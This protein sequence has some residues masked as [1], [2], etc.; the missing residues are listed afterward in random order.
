MKDPAARAGEAVVLTADEFAGLLGALKSDGYQ[1]IGPTVRD[2]AIVYGEIDGVG[3]MPAGLT[4]VQEA[5]TYRIRRR[6]D[7]ALFGYAVGPD[8]WK[9][10]LH[11]PTLRLWSARRDENRQLVVNEER[12][13]PAKM[14]FIGVRSCEIHAIAIQDKVLMG[15]A[16]VDP[17]Y[18]AR[19]KNTFIVAVNCIV[20]GGTCFCVSMRT[21]PRVSDGYDLAL[22]ELISGDRHDFLIEVGSQAGADAIS[23]VHPEP[24]D[25]AH[26]RAAAEAMQQ[27]ENQMGRSLD[28]T[29]IKELLYTNQQHPRW[30]EVASRCLGCGNCTAVCPTCFCTTIEDRVDLA[31]DN[32]EHIRR[33]D[34]CF[35]LD[36]SYLHGGSVR[37]SLKSRYRQWMTHKL[38]SWIDQFGTSGCVGCGRC[39]TWCPVGIDITEEVAAIRGT[40]RRTAPGQ[41]DELE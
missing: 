26:H 27:T 33:W 34:S 3:Q 12:D 2:E 18:A 41:A 11:L 5:G 38:A 35:T 23:K 20:A 29:A 21:G 37:T 39:I 28:T 7:Q 15:G 8:S 25:D 9:R 16:Y 4:E 19:R 17:H 24:A 31:G 14:A 36:F 1:L 32:A 22:T 6:S 13:E 10:L 30:D 40:D